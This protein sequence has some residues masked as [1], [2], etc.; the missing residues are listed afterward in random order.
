MAPTITF[1]PVGN[2][3]MTLIRLAD[4]TSI[5]IDVN[6][7]NSGAE[8]DDGCDVYDELLK[9]LPHDED[10]RPYGDVFLLT[11]P[12]ADH[13]RGI[14]KYFHLGPLEEYDFD[15]PEGEK[16]KIVLQEIWSSPMVFRRASKSLE[17]CDDAKGFQK[18]A[19]RR[20]RVYLESSGDIQP[21]DRIRIIGRDEEG[22]TDDLEDILTDTDET[23]TEINGKETGLVSVHI[24]GPLP[25]QDDEDQEEL[26]AKNRS[27]V[28]A[29][30]AIASDEEHT[31]ACLVLVGG[32]A[33]V[34]VWE[35]LWKKHS[36][37]PDC[38][39][40]DLL[41]GPHHCSWH[42]LSHDSWSGSGDPKVSPDARSAL[43][44]AGAGAF[45]VSSSVPITDDTADPPCVG[46]KHEYIDI[47]GKDGFF[48][49]GEYPKEENPEPLEFT[50][51]EEGPQGPSKKTSGRVAAAGVISTGQSFPHGQCLLG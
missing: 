22:K 49:T 21:G 1:F 15:P 33:E 18:E 20:V 10:D 25:K 51:T 8:E 47:V 26:L 34:A 36:E 24:L 32:D 6:I 27:S 42:S 16:L 50:V 45:I 29:Q 2:G 17:L 44:Q 37:D 7:K 14:L 28:I 11:H 48:C 38:L 4:E 39:A 9:R 35:R 43:S 41:L 12:D 3:D 19:K 13:C 30:F 31:G 46:A 40:Y 5:L 23:L